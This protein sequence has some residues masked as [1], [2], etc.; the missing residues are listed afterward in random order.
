MI[1]TDGL[2]L[3]QIPFEGCSLE[4]VKGE[5]R[6]KLTKITWRPD[7]NSTWVCVNV[8]YIL[9]THFCLERARKSVKSGHK[10]DA[11]DNFRGVTFDDWL[12][13]IIQV[14]QGISRSLHAR[15]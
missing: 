3:S 10:S 9:S 8:I 11:V 1:Y 7:S 15:C 4:I 5:G 12:R 14:S 2:L 6:Q 13:L